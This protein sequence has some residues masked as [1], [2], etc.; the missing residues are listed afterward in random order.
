MADSRDRLMRAVDIAQVFYGTRSGTL[1][2]FFDESRELLVSPG[3][4]RGPMGVGGGRLRDSGFGTLG[5]GIRLGRSLFR[6]QTP[7]LGRENAPCTGRGRGRRRAVS[8]RL[9]EREG[10][11][12][13][14]PTIPEDEGDVNSNVSS[15]DQLE[16]NFSTPTPT[17]RLK[18]PALHQSAT[19]QIFCLVS[20][21][22]MRGIGPSYTSKETLELHRHRR[23]SCNGGTAE[24]EEDSQCQESRK[25]KQSPHL[26]VNALIFTAFR[27]SENNCKA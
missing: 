11:A 27:I 7:A 9:G 12:I 3:R 15:G 8:Y 2:I 5:S 1:G 6:S 26:G 23:E 19:C 18:K 14:T 22:R 13:E 17:A 20:P 10:L 4:R 25:A 16:H 24:I 21:I